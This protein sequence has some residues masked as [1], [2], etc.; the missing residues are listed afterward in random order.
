MS[1]DPTTDFH[2]G[3]MHADECNGTTNFTHNYLQSEILFMGC[4]LPTVL[5]AGIVLGILL[6]PYAMA[7]SSAISHDFVVMCVCINCVRLAKVA[8]DTCN[9]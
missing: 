6:Y 8:Y 3:H 9:I 1:G 7:T 2:S 4:C 5:V